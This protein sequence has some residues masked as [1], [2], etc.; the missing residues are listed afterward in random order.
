VVP[1]GLVV[2]F[3]FVLGGD[4]WSPLLLDFLESKTEEPKTEVQ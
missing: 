2:L 3:P 4:F 1:Q